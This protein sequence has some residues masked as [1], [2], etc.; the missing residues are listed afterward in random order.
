MFNISVIVINKL[1]KA[2]ATFV[3]SFNFLIFT[4]NIHPLTVQ[5]SYHKKIK[6]ETIQQHSTLLTNPNK[7][8]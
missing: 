1:L 2:L 7:S 6:S 4:S 5:V 3:G 8:N